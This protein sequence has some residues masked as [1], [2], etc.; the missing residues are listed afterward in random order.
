MENMQNKIVHVTKD[1]EQFKILVGNR[2]VDRNRVKKIRESIKSV[3]YISN[4]IIVNERMEIIDGQGRLEALKSLDMPVEFIVQPGLSVKECIAMNINHTN[5]K[6]TD[7]I[8]S[9][10]DTGNENYVRLNDLIQKFPNVSVFVIESVVLGRSRN[11]KDIIKNGMLECTEEIYLKSFDILTYISRFDFY[12]RGMNGKPSLFQYALSVC[13]NLDC[14]D[15]ER[16]LDKVKT[17][18][19][20]ATNFSTIFSCLDEIEKMYNRKSKTEYAYILTDYKK[21]LKEKSTD[22]L[23]LR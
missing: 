3:G 4:P 21:K 12:T 6:H 15:N 7:Y 14:V 16:L 17:Y 8:K 23:L 11:V 10:A 13:Y 22:N 19:Y 9:Y 1:Y 18:G 20:I 2:N 5:W